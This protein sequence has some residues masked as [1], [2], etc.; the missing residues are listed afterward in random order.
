MRLI[1]TRS[2]KTRSKG[3]GIRELKYT[4]GVL[5]SVQHWDI[6]SPQFSSQG[7]PS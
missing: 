7:R 3:R 2:Q 5:A 1:Q 4:Q 6:V